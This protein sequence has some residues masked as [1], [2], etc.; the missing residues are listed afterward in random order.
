[1]ASGTI[2]EITYQV[3]ENTEKNRLL[4][5]GGDTSAA[6]SNRLGIKGMKVCKVEQI[7][8]KSNKDE[9]KEEE[10]VS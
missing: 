4:I 8:N 6:V 7:D 10:D 3:V 1:M 2:A 5:A 9:D